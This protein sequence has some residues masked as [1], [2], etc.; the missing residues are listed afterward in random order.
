MR[1]GYTL[2]ETLTVVALIAILS[3]FMFVNG[4]T[5]TD[6]ALEFKALHST[7]M[8]KAS[9]E[10][11][12]LLSSNDVE[13]RSYE[14]EGKYQV[15]VK[16]CGDGFEVEIY[17]KDLDFTEDTEDCE[18]EDLIQIASFDACNTMKAIPKTVCKI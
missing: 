8:Q 17:D 11:Y 18:Q 5:A 14:I 16:T 9:D 1:K 2:F 3:S 4:K 10:A 12:K 13:E 7:L 15:N 6:K